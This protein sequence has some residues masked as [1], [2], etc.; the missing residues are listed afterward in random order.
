MVHGGGPQTTALQKQLGQEPNVVAGRRITDADALEVIK[1][2]VAG[3]LN[4]DLCSA[5]LSAGA[6]PV[7]LHGASSQAIAAC[8]RPPRVV[9]GGGDQPI[10]FGFVGDVLGVNT[11]LLSRLFEGGYVPVLACVGADVDG[12]VY[13]I[14]ADVIANQVAKHVKAHALVLVTSAPGVVR[15]LADLSTRIPTMTV[16]EA[17]AAIA[18]GTVQGGM[19]PKLDESIRVLENGEVSAIHIVGDLESG[20]LRRELAEPG[21]IGTALLP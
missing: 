2:A 11:D 20:D 3:K 12:Q 14:N 19:I 7:G 1:M 9:A 17:R 16:A 13:N 21:S 8:K 10:D 4:V 15:D 18:D 6:K 5:L